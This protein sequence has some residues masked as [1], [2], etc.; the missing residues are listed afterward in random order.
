MNRRLI[1]ICAVIMIAMA[2]PAFAA[3]QNVKVSGDIDAYG[4][5]RNNFD[6]G[7][8][9][10]GTT[11]G[12]DNS[13]VFMSQVRLRVDA[14]LTDN[15]SSTIRLLNERD[16]DQEVTNSSAV[17]LDL[18]YVTLKEMLYSPL[19][20]VVGRQPL[21]YGNALIIG[22]PDTNRI[23]NDAD[24]TILNQDLSVRKAFDAVKAVLNY[25]PLTI[26][27][28]YSL[29]DENTKLGGGVGPEEKDDVNLYGVNA[30][31]KVGDA[32]DSTIEGY[33]FYKEDQ[34]K[35][36]TDNGDT[37]SVPGVKI[38]TNPIKGLNLQAEQAWQF[39]S[40]LM[41]L[42]SG[43]YTT[44]HRKR[45]A[46]A[47]QILATYALQLDSLMKYSPV[48]GAMFTRFSGDKNAA[49]TGGGRGEYKAW[50]PMFEDQGT[51]TIYNVLFQ[52][53]NTKVANGN[54]SVKP[55]EDLTAKLDWTGIWLDKELNISRWGNG[56]ADLFS[57]Y[58]INNGSITPWMRE[59]KTFLGQEIDANLTYDYTE[60]VQLGLMGGVFIPGKAFNKTDD[61]NNNTATNPDSED[62][63]LATQL[64]ASCKVTF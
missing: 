50:D 22:D 41:Q 3:V 33:F 51:G 45:E 60:D 40:K 43:A 58:Q 11:G 36:A 25:D 10:S 6:L 52:T 44:L 13:G 5:S 62:N 16:W 4:I 2:I 57:L 12:K 37:I 34:K 47:T 56:N 21:R 17:D 31:Y 59:G 53:T 14:D 23:T 7:R 27:V 35:R 42:S 15:V 39:G 30:N 54:V 26:D 63:R 1:L 24:T 32:F 28:F 55:I 64:I 18:A 8:K 48:I 29:I 19:T 46:M 20:I 9:I 61:P 38:S 49:D